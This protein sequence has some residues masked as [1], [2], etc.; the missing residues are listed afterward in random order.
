M[1]YVF[2]SLTFLGSLSMAQTQGQPAQPV[3][4]ELDMAVVCGKAGTGKEGAVMVLNDKLS[5]GDAHFFSVQSGELDPIFGIVRY[6]RWDYIK[7]PVVVSGIE[8]ST[9][10]SFT[11]ACVHVNRK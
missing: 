4:R 8:F 6:Q 10:Q 3:G 9:E 2:L 11:L 7:K 1:K 5:R